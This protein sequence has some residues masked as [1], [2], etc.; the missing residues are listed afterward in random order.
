MVCQRQGQRSRHVL[1]V[2]R[3]TACMTA[4]S[5]PGLVQGSRC[6]VGAQ[7][8]RFCKFVM[9]KLLVLI[10]W[11]R[12]VALFVFLRFTSTVLVEVQG[13]ASAVISA[14]AQLKCI[15]SLPYLTSVPSLVSVHPP[16]C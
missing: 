1:A 10:E 9:D 12:Q 15:Q 3:A 14:P 6:L 2:V 4:R 16:L 11:S 7:P 13:T 8:P 5:W